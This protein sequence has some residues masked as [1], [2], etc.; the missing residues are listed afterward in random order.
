LRG[1]LHE[2]GVQ[3]DSHFIEKATLI[4]LLSRVKRIVKE[5]LRLNPTFL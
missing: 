2:L 5:Q 3:V 1:C 4:A